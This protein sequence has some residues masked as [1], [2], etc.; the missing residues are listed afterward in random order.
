MCGVNSNLIITKEQVNLFFYKYSLKEDDYID[1]FSLLD[2]SIDRNIDYS[3]EVY[4]LKV[5]IEYLKNSIGF[6]DVIKSLRKDIM[7]ITMELINVE[8]ILYRKIFYNNIIKENIKNETNNK[9]YYPK[10]SCI[11]HLYRIIFTCKPNPYHYDFSIQSSVEKVENDVIFQIKQRF[12]YSKR[13]SSTCFYSFTTR[14][15]PVE[16]HSE[17]E[18]SDKTNKS[19]HS[20]IISDIFPY[21]LS[22]GIKNNKIFPL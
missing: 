21:K 22:H 20:S 6:S 9:L 2:N 4:D 1:L 16:L 18:Q 10:E 12:G 13:G 7:K 8:E 15:I 11:N 5:F 14:S 17:R 19:T 3:S